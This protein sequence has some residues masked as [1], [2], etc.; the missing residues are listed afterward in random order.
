VEFNTNN[1]E[2]AA[3]DQIKL[4]N[5]RKLIK[6]PDTGPGSTLAEYHRA[7]ADKVVLISNSGHIG[8][9]IEN[10][11]YRPRLVSLELSIDASP[12]TIGGVATSPAVTTL[13]PCNTALLVL[14]KPRVVCL[15]SRR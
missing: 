4:E 5:G 11:L 1:L 8:G 7:V 15:L 2:V 13:Q 10:G 9:I 12:L 14:S 6:G 3:D